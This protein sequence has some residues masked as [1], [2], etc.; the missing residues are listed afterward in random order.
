MRRPSVS[1]ALRL[2]ALAAVASCASSPDK[3]RVVELG[4]AEVAVVGRYDAPQ[5]DAL[6]FGWSLTTIDARF[7]GPSLAMDVHEDARSGET[8]RFAV[9]V[10]DRDAVVVQ[11]PRGRSVVP[12][13]D[14][15]DDGEHVVRIVRLTE[16]L[17][18]ESTLHGLVVAE[19]FELLDPPPPRAR[20]IEVLGDSLTAGYGNLGTYADCP[21]SAATEDARRAWPGVAADDLDADAVVLAWS[22]K[23]VLRN[24]DVAD[25]VTMPMLWERAV[26]TDDDSSWPFDDRE[27]DVV[28]VF[29][30]ANDFAQGVPDEDA[31]TDAYH[32]LLDDVRARR[33]SAKLVLVVPPLSDEWP[34]GEMQATKATTFVEAVAAARDDVDRVVAFPP[35]LPEEGMGCSWHPT[36]ATHARWA[37]IM[38]SELRALLE[39]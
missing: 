25:A 4:D 11:P 10:D 9:L 16:P 2:F 36:A 17:V 1:A 5:D 34:E 15:L 22:G 20:R 3:P 38:T 23:G 27:P 30:G 29:L 33:P 12:L 39:W 19:G 18:G 21:F 35:S 31:F 8:N 6:R 14:G 37:S 13:V 24:Y 7:T 32:G 28:I 26:P